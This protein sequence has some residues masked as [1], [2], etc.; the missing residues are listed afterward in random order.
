M[1]LYVL[2]SYPEEA[3]SPYEHIR[4][5]L[6]V[7]LHVGKLPYSRGEWSI[8][9]SRE[10]LLGKWLRGRVEMCFSRVI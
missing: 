5:F 3:F 9:L 2:S 8:I 1:A 10:N 6:S 7:L 4:I